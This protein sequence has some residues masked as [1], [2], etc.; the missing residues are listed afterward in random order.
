LKISVI[1]ALERSLEEGVGNVDW[2]ALAFLENPRLG[3]GDGLFWKAKDFGAASRDTGG[4]GIE[5]PD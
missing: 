3:P 4:V 2:Q 1:G 5:A